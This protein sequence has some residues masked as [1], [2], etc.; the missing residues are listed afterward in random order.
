M[1]RDGGPVLNLSRVEL[2]LPFDSPHERIR[3][4]VL[5]FAM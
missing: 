2:P 3:A 1:A 4:N 5:G